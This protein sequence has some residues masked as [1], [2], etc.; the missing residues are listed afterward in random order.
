[1]KTPFN[2]S[3]EEAK[4]IQGD[5]AY[6]NQ[7]ADNIENYVLGHTPFSVRT[8]EVTAIHQHLIDDIKAALTKYRAAGRALE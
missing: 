8:Q 5:K 1:M 7:T 3:N 4:A 6:I 2:E